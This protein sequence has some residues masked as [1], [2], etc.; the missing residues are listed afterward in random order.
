MSQVCWGNDKG[1]GQGMNMTG[2]K[3]TALGAAG[4]MALSTIS[5]SGAVVATPPAHHT[6]VAKVAVWS[7]FG[8]AGDIIAA[9]CG[10]ACPLQPP[11]HRERGDDLRHR[12]LARSGTGETQAPLGAIA[13]LDTLHNAARPSGVFA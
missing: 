10:R 12:L 9:A 11:A 1:M 13:R 8:C 4:L 3:L 6:T 7:I 2:K 5:A